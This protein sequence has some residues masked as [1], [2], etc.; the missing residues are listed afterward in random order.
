MNGNR[1]CRQI[2]WYEDDSKIQAWRTGKT[3]FP[4]IDAC[5]RQMVSD[6]LFFILISFNIKSHDLWHLKM[7]LKVTEGFVHHIGRFAVAIFLTVGDL[8]LNWEH[9]Q[10]ECEIIF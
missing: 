7:T 6:I 1:I 2:E 4:W 10:V 3:G 5:M 8:W 9:G